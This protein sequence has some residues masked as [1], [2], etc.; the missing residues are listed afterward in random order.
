MA[1]LTG[2][3]VKDTYTSLL[4]LDTNGLTSTLK[5][6]E[7]GA[8]VV[9][10]IKLST[11]TVEVDGT[12]SFTAAPATDAA[13]LTVLL[14]DSSNNVVK[15]VKHCSLYRHSLNILCKPNVCIETD[16]LRSCRH[17]SH[18]KYGRCKQQLNNSII[19]I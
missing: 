2:N 5:S 15:R 3:K 7:D 4:K 8:G 10:A 11:N 6:I 12:L 9:S 19:H 18:S 13:E 14:V 1:T 17:A 16:C